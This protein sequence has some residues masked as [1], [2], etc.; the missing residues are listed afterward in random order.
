[1][2]AVTQRRISMRGL[3]KG[4]MKGGAVGGLVVVSLGFLVVFLLVSL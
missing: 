2:D 4:R 1:M 3:L